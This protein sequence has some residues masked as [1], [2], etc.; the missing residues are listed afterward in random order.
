MVLTV[1]C[2]RLRIIIRKNR[3]RSR[4]ASG[5]GYRGAK[6]RNLPARRKFTLEIPD[7]ITL[8]GSPSVRESMAL[9]VMGSVTNVCSACALWAEGP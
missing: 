8:A 4:D 3:S 2:F 9:L 1:D 5:L 6:V 7:F